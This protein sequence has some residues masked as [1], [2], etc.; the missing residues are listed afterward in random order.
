MGW[1]GLDMERAGLLECFHKRWI[2][3]VV[4]VDFS[5]LAGLGGGHG[6]AGPS[7]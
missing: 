4:G 6:A 3:L 5:P 7:S 2:G 1:I